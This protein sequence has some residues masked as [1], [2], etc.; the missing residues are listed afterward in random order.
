MMTVYKFE[1]PFPLSELLAAPPKKRKEEQTPR[2]H[3]LNIYP[4]QPSP[5]KH[6]DFLLGNGNYKMT[7]SEERVGEAGKRG[8]REGGSERG[9]MGRK[10]EKKKR[11]EERHS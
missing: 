2:P 1:S 11:L 5:G 7:S 4:S 8:G 9:E 6:N 10:K 3:L